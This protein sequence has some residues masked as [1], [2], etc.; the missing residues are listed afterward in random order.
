MTTEMNLIGDDNDVYSQVETA[1]C[2]WEAIIESASRKSDSAW[3][4]W[5]TEEQGVFHGRMK[6]AEIAWLFDV[7][8]E[9]GQDGD[10][11]ALDGLAFDWEIVPTVLDAFVAMFESPSQVT[12]EAAR[13]VGETLPAIL[14][15]K[16]ERE[17]E[18]EED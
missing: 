13:Q 10:R 4:N 18:L 16:Q 14:K 6:C 1:L 7:A 11:Y 3:Y 15:A 8:Y 12:V 5:I 17:H 9:T 2:V